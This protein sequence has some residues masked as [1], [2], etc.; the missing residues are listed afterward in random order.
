MG[1][2]RYTSPGDIEYNISQI[3]PDTHLAGDIEYSITQITQDTQH[4]TDNTRY[5]SHG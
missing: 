5:T 3:T 1:N 2:I 4:L